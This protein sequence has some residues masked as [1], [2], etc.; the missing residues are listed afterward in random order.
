M[1]K[2]VSIQDNSSD[3]SEEASIMNEFY[4]SNGG[5]QHLK[6]KK[7]HTRISKKEG[8]DIT[9]SSS[10]QE[11][12]K[13]QK[14]LKSALKKP[15]TPGLG[16]GGVIHLPPLHVEDV[17]NVSD[18]IHRVTLQ[19]GLIP[20]SNNGTNSKDNQQIDPS[21]RVIQ[22]PINSLDKAAHMGELQFKNMMESST[23]KEILNEIITVHNEIQSI[24]HQLGHRPSLASQL[25]E[26]NK[27]NIKLFQRIISEILMLHRHKFQSQTTKC[28]ELEGLVTSL[29][30]RSFYLQEELVI[31]K[32]RID[33]LDN[34]CQEYEVLCKAKDTEILLL[35]D[36]LH[37]L[38]RYQAESLQQLEEEKRLHEREQEEIKSR[39]NKLLNEER[40]IL[41]NQRHE[42]MLQ[43]CSLSYP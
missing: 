16:I 13:S 32:Q 33:K 30:E 15:Q 22:T 1:K 28:H 42:M 14:E 11:I 12:K 20:G 4:Q 17:N 3:I 18:I 26:A 24:V 38:E 31:S 9:K 36:Q 7:G 5:F 21:G 37:E 2:R 6:S 39:Y 25:T 19:S 8:N 35:S 27:L 29:Q 41:N 40:N 10:Q 43:V 34:K 23:I